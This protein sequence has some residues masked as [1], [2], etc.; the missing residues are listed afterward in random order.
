[1]PAPAPDPAIA[2]AIVVLGMH[3]SGTSC[4]AGMIAAAGLASAGAAVRNWDNARGHHEMLD[5]VRLNEAV[6]AHSGGHWLA[7]PATVRWTDDHAAARDRLLCSHVDGR[8]ALLK[9]PRTLLVL[10]FWRA[11][12]VPFR[13]VG[14][15]RHPLAVARSLA[16]WREMPL[17]DAI[18]LWLA[19]VRVLAEDHARHGY[20]V[21]DFGAS[22]PDVIAAL[23]AAFAPAPIDPAA[24]VD[25]L[26]HH[27][28]GDP[29]ALPGLDDAAALYH[30]L[31]AP[32]VRLA[33]P[34]FPRAE[35]AAFET[36]LAA[37][38]LAPA[39]TAA[40]AALAAIPDAAAVLVP[41]VT[42][43]VRRRAHAAAR[44]L[45][46]EHAARLDPGVADLLLGK[47]LLAM[48]APADALLHLTA[49]CAQPHPPF[50][51]RHLL[52]QALRGAG[53]HAE[54]RTALRRV[55]ADAL[56]PH[57]PLATLAEWS[58]LDGD[59][60][61]ALAELAD[62]I[63]AA[64]HHRRGRLR[65]RRAEWLLALGDPAAARREL[66]HALAED[67][68]YTRA[69]EMLSGTLG[70]M[71]H[72]VT[73]EHIPSRILAAV[74][75]TPRRG[76]IGKAFGPALDLVWPYLR[77]HPGLRTDGHN[78]F[79]YHHVDDPDALPVD[80][81][82][83]V[84]RR[85]EPDDP[86]GEIRCVETPSGEAAVVVHRGPYTGLHEAH[87]AIDRW[88]AANGRRI[89]G[90]S[91]EIYGDWTDDPTQLETTIQYLLR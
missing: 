76:E 9:D 32:H 87:A 8:A 80:F 16:A 82:V 53:H 69:R 40:R 2:P 62:A 24:Y 72:A 37:G 52:A 7:A 38:A 61:R 17:A 44:T 66:H 41:A 49:A 14:V 12:T 65:T 64:P 79:L 27:D 25:E 48:N 3:R 6:L 4:V 56:Y 59:R 60:P 33:R 58:W 89:G 46:T 30:R 34:R 71:D 31:A 26:V 35:L 20:P 5:V 57:N 63:T 43:L 78:V 68:R 10:P 29:P 77:A 23:A 47:V 21:I 70:A 50:Q 84:T 86:A 74:R 36:A 28:D 15:V 1:M 51:A 45:I 54:A 22:R 55:A 81:G 42:T 18:A 75:R 85:F 90:F 91:L 88:C 83:E 11:S 39:L 73:L 13:V 19:H 67:P